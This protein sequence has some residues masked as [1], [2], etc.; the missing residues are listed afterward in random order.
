MQHFLPVLIA[1]ALRYLIWS[2]FPLLLFVFLSLVF[3]LLSLLVLSLLYFVS[4]FL[5]V[6][7]SRSFVNLPFCLLDFVEV[8]FLGRTKILFYHM[9]FFDLPNDTR[10]CSF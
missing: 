9:Y 8:A 5:L 10:Q 3:Q 6:S 2:V 4:F 7:P 1:G